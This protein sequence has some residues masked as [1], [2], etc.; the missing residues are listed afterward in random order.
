VALCAADARAY[1]YRE[2][3]RRAKADLC[4]MYRRGVLTPDG[5]VVRYGGGMHPPER[6]RKDEV[7]TSIL[8]IE[9]PPPAAPERPAAAVQNDTY[10]EL[11]RAELAELRA[12]AHP[13][14]RCGMAADVDPVLHESRYGHRPKY[15]DESGRVFVWFAGRWAEKLDESAGGA[16]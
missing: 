7:V 12:G 10:G 3:S 4:A 5:Q 15:R 6:W 11:T 14:L 9:I 16:S 2:L 1:R 13:C 8:S